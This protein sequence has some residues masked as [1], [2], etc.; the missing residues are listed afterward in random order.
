MGVWDFVSQ[1][2]DVDMTRVCQE[3]VP[4][5]FTEQGGNSFLV[6]THLIN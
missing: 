3:G 6:P 2:V 1:F 5:E 4:C